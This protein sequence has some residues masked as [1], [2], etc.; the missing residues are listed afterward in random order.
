MKEKK[1]SDLLPHILKLK[2]FFFFSNI[3]RYF[4]FPIEKFLFH[5]CQLKTFLLIEKE[6]LLLEKKK[7][8]FQ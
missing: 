7:K 6:K 5:L 2:S 8:I 4:N 3:T 1:C